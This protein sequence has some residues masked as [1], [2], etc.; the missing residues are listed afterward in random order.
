MMKLRK[1]SDIE[2]FFEGNEPPT[3]SKRLLIEECQKQGVCVYVDDEAEQMDN[4]PL[5]AVASEAELQK[6]LNQAKA[7][8]KAT[9]SNVIAFMALLVAICALLVAIF[10]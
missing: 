10:K 6:R 1:K 9:T 4:H 3:S 8:K 2:K 7:L 5:K